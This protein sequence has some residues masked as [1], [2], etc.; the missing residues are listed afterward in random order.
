MSYL[1]WHT[2]ID[3]T[4]S[5]ES[6][7]DK[8]FLA[9]EPGH[10]LMVSEWKCGHGFLDVRTGLHISPTHLAYINAPFPIPI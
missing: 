9:Y 5:G 2:I 8:L 4:H 3:V 10:P 7:N 1:E 6:L